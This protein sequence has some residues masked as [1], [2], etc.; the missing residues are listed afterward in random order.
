M[1]ILLFVMI[2]CEFKLPN[3]MT[4]LNRIIKMTDELLFK[5]IRLFQHLKMSHLKEF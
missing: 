5:K 3:L 1:D 2:H 4:V